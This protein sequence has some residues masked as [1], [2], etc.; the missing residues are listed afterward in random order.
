M[1]KEPLR[2][3]P[4]GFG[5]CGRCAY[6]DT[7]TSSICFACA[8][9]TMEDLAAQRCRTCDLPLS[10]G[11]G[12]RNPICNWDSRH[13]GWNYAVAMR[14]GT[15]QRAI[16]AYKYDDRRGWA[17]IFA[18]VLVGFLNQE[19]ETFRPFDLIVASPTYVGPDGRAFDHTR[20]VL[21]WAKDWAEGAWPFDLEEPAAIIKTA[22]TE[23]MVRKTWKQRY[24]IAK[25]PL[26]DAL[27]LPRPERTRGKRILVYDDVFTDGQTLNE[28]AGCLRLQG[29]A[30]WVCGV[31]LAR[32]PYGGR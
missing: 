21:E 4:A 19:R 9:R 27:R 3:E 31:T 8:R 1:A 32:Q 24:E 28:V 5:A 20:F 22:P 23:S 11:E 14:S 17:Q 13:F 18:R 16:N 15:L 6:L 10:S 26:R 30:S 2:P 7:G 25:G 29:E 12:C